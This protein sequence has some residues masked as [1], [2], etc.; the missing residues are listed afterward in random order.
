MKT[1]SH[2][3]SRTPF[4]LALLL[5]IL[6]F[7]AINFLSF[8]KYIRKDYSLN[9]YTELSSQTENVLKNLTDPVDITYCGATGVVDD[10]AAHIQEDVQRLLEQYVQKSGGKIKVRRI[11]PFTETEKAQQLVQRFKL[12]DSQDVL[13]LERGERSKILTVSDLAEIDF[14]GSM[15]GQPPRVKSFNAEAHITSALLSL[16]SGKSAKVYF[17][18]GHGEPDIKAPVEDPTS[19]SVLASRV[20][21]QN[22]TVGTT[23]LELE[24]KVPEDAD[25]LVII[26]PQIPF[27][28]NEISALTDYITRRHGNLLIALGPEVKTGLENL[29]QPYGLQFQDDIVMRKVLALSEEGP[30]QAITLSAVG[31]NFG[32]HPSIAWTRWL[33]ETQTMMPIGRSRSLLLKDTNSNPLQPEKKPLA[34][35]LIQTTPQEWGETTF[36]NWQ[37]AKP[38][39]N[40]QSDHKG[41]LVLAAVLDTGSIDSNNNVRVDGA[42]VIAVGAYDFLLNKEIGALGAD[43]FTNSMNWLIDQQNALGISPKQP[44]TM[45]ISF[46]DAQKRVIAGITMLGV[47]GVGLLLWLIVWWRRR[48]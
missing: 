20:K 5:F 27:L 47:P 18:V 45:A 42:R 9:R 7:L 31:A 39:F 40:P 25:L 34:Q 37:T 43:F 15:M 17:T 2:L 6:I 4:Y 33:Q 1:T 28:P 19:L 14:S 35:W 11:N 23:N 3:W 16:T 12:A 8:K 24:G 22:A 36:G 38:E 21:T 32:D 26:G 29:L 48:T 10:I 30:K 13:I 41:P 44:K 46:T